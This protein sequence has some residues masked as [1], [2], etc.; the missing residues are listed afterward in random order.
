MT[1]DNELY[2]GLKDAL[3][4]INLNIEQQEEAKANAIRSIERF[5]RLLND[6]QNDIDRIESS[7][8]AKDFIGRDV[9]DKNKLPCLRNYYRCW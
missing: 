2:E 1:S 9:Q 6:Y 7:L 5:S 3:N 4:T 8:S